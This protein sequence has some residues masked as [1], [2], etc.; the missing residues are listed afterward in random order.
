MNASSP[1]DL[2][3]K[4]SAKQLHKVPILLCLK[5]LKLFS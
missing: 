1:L 4:I 2:K 5:T 3:E